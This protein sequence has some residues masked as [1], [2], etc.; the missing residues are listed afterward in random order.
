MDIF[1]EFMLPFKIKG[2]NEDTS[3]LFIHDD[4]SVIFFNFREDRARE[5]TSAFLQKDFNEFKKDVIV[6]PF[7]VCMTEY[8]QGLSDHI[9]YEQEHVSS[10]LSSIF[11][12]QNMKQFKIAETEKYAHVTYF[13]NGGREVP[14][15]LEDRYLIPSLHIPTYDTQ[16]AMKAFE[17]TA[18]LVKKIH[19]RSYA[20]LVANFANADMV[21]HTGNLDATIKACEYVDTCIGRII[22][23]VFEKKG[24]LIITGDHGNAEIKYNEEKRIIA[25]AHTTSPVPFI[26]AASDITK[27]TLLDRGKLGDIAPTMLHAL[28]LDTSSEMTGFNL[29]A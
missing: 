21:G 25:T 23:A 14:Y 8:A 26:L 13:L 18:E 5:L 17:I 29:L 6:H 10:P 15:A 22:E 2:N 9:A 11:A 3:S 19:S 28:G 4:D 27:R 24:L 7:F 20:L 12:L 16:P 1:D